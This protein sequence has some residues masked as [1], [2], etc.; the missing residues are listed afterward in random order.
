MQGNIN[1]TRFIYETQKAFPTATGDFSAILNQIA[2]AAKI[3]S[4]EVNRAGILD[5]VLGYQGETNPSGD[6]QKKLDVIADNVFFNA[7]EHIEKFCIMGSEENENPVKLPKRYK[8]GRYAIL[9]DPLDG[10]SN[11][12]FN[13]SI[14]TIFSVFRRTSPEGGDGNLQDLLQPGYKQ[15]AAGYVLYGS[16]TMMTFTTGQG[17]N[18]FTLDPQIGEFILTHPNI[19]IPDATRYYSINEGNSANW[20]DALRSYVDTLKTSDNIHGKVLSGRYIGSM[21]ADVH[22]TL[23]GG[24]FFSYPADSANPS[25]KLRLMYEANPMAMVIE[26]AGGRAIY[27]EG[28]IMGI[29]P[30]ELHQ[31]IPVFLG[32][33]KDIDALQRA[34]FGK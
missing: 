31:K 32:S 7:L 2:L 23:L 13:V 3:V 5:D 9:F 4:M 25:G 20:S 29:I 28:D 30:R 8:K 33:K 6:D 10:S 24:G 11:I 16:S 17:V 18:M 12:D 1:L 14:G 21:V 27:G 34:V 15:V 26:Q 19:R 22:R